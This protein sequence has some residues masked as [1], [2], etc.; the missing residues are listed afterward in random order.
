MPLPQSVAI[1]VLDANGGDN[2][3]ST[4]KIYSMNV[5]GR[6]KGEGEFDENGRQI[7]DISLMADNIYV[8]SANAKTS[9]VST[10]KNPKGY[11]PDK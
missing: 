2:S 10:K 5:K 1:E 3:E 7:A 4:L 6:N 9:S 11:K 8:N